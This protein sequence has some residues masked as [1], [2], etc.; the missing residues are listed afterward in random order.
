ML[1]F[2][3][4]INCVVCISGGMSGSGGMASGLG[5]SGSGL[6]VGGLGGSGLGSLGLGGS[7]LGSNALGGYGDYERSFDSRGGRDDYSGGRSSDTIVVRNVSGGF[8]F[9]F[10]CVNCGW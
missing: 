9:S 4:V 8:Q 7:S 5:M 3:C 1:P 6:G 2:N 10:D